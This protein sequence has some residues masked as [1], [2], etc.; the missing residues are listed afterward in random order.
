MINGIYS[1][2]VKTDETR[3]RPEPSA[4]PSEDPEPASHTDVPPRGTNRLYPEI[5]TQTVD[6][7]ELRRRRLARFQ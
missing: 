6:Q 4:P 1:F 7:E 2:F 3:R 5:P